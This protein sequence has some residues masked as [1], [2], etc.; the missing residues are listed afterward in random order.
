[1]TVTQEIK[2]AILSSTMPIYMRM[3][4]KHMPCGRSR[5]RGLLDQYT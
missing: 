1:M 5:K 2:R 3:E 4:W